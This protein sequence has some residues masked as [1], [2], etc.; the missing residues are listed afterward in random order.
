[1]ESPG[2]EEETY[3]LVEYAFEYTSKDGQVIT[4]KP[5]E[6]YILLRRTNDHWWHVRKSKNSRPFYI[7]AK[8]VRELNPFMPSERPCHTTQLEAI[9]LGTSIG[10][11]NDQ[12]PDYEYRFVTAVQECKTDTSQQYPSSLWMGTLMSLEDNGKNL[13]NSGA[14][15]GTQLSLSASYSSL[16]PLYLTDSN[17]PMASQ[18]GSA[19]HMRPAVSLNDL[20]RFTP[21]TQTDVGNSGLYKTASWAQPH[22]FLKNSSENI[23][24]LVKDQVI[25]DMQECCAKELLEDVATDPVYVNLQELQLE[26][27]T[28]TARDSQSPFQLCLSNSLNN[29]EIH[30]D[31]KSGH[32]FYYNSVTGQT[33]WESPFG[34]PFGDSVSLS[35]SHCPSPV[36]SAEWNQYVDKASG[37]IFFYNAATGETSW[38]APQETFNPPEM[39]PAFTRRSSDRR[40]PTPETDYP[41]F[42][43][44]E[45]EVSPKEGYSP[46][47]SYKQ[48]DYAGIPSSDQGCA[49][50]GTS[51]TSMF[52][53]PDMVTTSGKRPS[54]SSGSSRGSSSFASWFPSQ[55]VHPG[56][57]DKQLKSLEKAGM[58]Y[59][60][61]TADKG[62]RLRKNW[63]CV[64]T[65][66]EG[67]ALIFFKDSKHSSSSS[68]KYPSVLS[69]PEFNVNLHGASL[70]WAHK[71]RSSRKNV[72]EL[73]TQDGSEY[74][75]QHDL[76]SI[77]SMWHSAISHRIGRLSIDFPLEVVDDNLAAVKSKEQTGGSKEKE[78]EK[79]H[80]AFWHSHGSDSDSSKIRY[81]LRKFL[82]KRPPLQ[83]LRDRGYIKDQVFGCSLQVL[84]DRE[85]STVPYFVRQCI[86]T[87]EKRGL[88]IDGL[89]RISGN[90]A[91]IQNLRYR[92]DH[93]EYL[94]LDS[95]QWDDVH[96]ITGALKLF[97]RELPEPLFPFRFFN[98]LIAAAEVIDPAK[99]RHHLREV[100][101]SLPPANFNTSR[102]LFQH[103]S[104]VVEFR[105]KNRMSQQSVAIV[106]GPTL[107]RPQDEEENIAMYMFFQNQVMEQILS[108]TSYIFPES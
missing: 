96:V 4:I 99:R 43:S 15:R 64:W 63:A 29:W 3:V 92:V 9:N 59:R 72:L 89:Y 11:A 39:R 81:M 20:P 33:T 22:P 69:N 40:P 25:Q 16:K 24:K 41:K 82:L 80:P 17:H 36:S 86:A 27:S 85:K 8:Y 88:D 68:T 48:F 78:S 56:S 75:I 37:Q 32:F 83:Y 51:E 104:R 12:L 28:T 46:D 21:P 54:T 101:H 34:A 77:A 71:D 10:V 100:V 90:L 106:F 60:T 2:R 38:E 5:N 58:L 49:S 103:L 44:Y 14:A 19:E 107:L 31:T 87:V 30:T 70:S 42:S 53:V 66:L 108:Q 23:R 1:M 105:E 74:L 98:R 26:H 73:K 62:K 6:R 94:D 13:H 79:K 52:E 55:S 67:G 102:V 47:G 18:G 7:P 50:P 45:H 84:C 91:T 65:V 97:F 95:G 76:D 35:H 57:K 93:D 61:R